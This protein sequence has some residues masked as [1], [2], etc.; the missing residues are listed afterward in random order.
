LARLSALSPSDG[1]AT[2]AFEAKIITIIT[3]GFLFAGLI[4]TVCFD[5]G[6]GLLP[7]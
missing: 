5:W 7:S 1:A 3:T 4:F 6:A 2:S